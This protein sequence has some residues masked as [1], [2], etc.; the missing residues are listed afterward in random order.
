MTR[1]TTPMRHPFQMVGATTGVEPA[2]FQPVPSGYHQPT[3]VEAW[4]LYPLSYVAET[5]CLPL[6]IETD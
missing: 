5:Y 1:G 3:H 6:A 2:T 4:M